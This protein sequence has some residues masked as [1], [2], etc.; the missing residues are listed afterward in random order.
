MRV[1]TALLIAQPCAATDSR[2]GEIVAVDEVGRIT[3]DRTPLDNERR[4]EHHSVEHQ[5]TEKV[6]ARPR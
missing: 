5:H 2:T 6:V 4:G 1:R 3:P